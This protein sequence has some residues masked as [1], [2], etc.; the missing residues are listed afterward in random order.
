MVNKYIWPAWQ[1]YSPREAIFGP[2][3]KF[4]GGGAFFEGQK[5]LRST[6][7][8]FKIVYL[9]SHR[10]MHTQRFINFQ[11][12]FNCR[13]PNI[14]C[15]WRNVTS[16]HFFIFMSLQEIRAQISDT[17]N[18]FNNPG[19]HPSIRVSAGA[20]RTPPTPLATPLAYLHLSL[21]SVG[22]RTCLG[23]VPGPL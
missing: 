5:Y 6:D 8:I 12:Q 16:V 7:L 20:V 9:Q 23:S 21:C 10:C 1:K 15:M 4:S 19:L 2:R 22:R 11:N 17:K 14:S 13:Y 3:G 18:Y